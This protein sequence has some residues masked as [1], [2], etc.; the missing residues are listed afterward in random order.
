M[1]QKIR[2]MAL[3]RTARK[4]EV[5]FRIFGERYNYVLAMNR[6]DIHYPHILVH[7][8]HGH[9]MPPEEGQVVLVATAKKKHAFYKITKTKNDPGWWSG[10]W[11]FE[12]DW[13]KVDLEFLGMYKKQGEK[14]SMVQRIEA[15]GK[16]ALLV[17]LVLLAT[18]AFI[19]LISDLLPSDV[20][21][22][23]KLLLFF[24]SKICA[25][26][27]LFLCYVVYGWAYERGY[28]PKV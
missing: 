1:K 3:R 24:I 5:P 9:Y 14:N 13:V 15:V 12:Y 4:N 27:L 16:W 19:V 10:G 20:L 6:E 11:T 25:L 23:N 2:D 17:S 18:G 7:N 22:A 26:S 28:I 21:T 8:E